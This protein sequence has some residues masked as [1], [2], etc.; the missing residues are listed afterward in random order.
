MIFPG[1]AQVVVGPSE[2]VVGPSENHL[3]NV[4]GQGYL[5]EAGPNPTSSSSNA[6]QSISKGSV[7]YSLPL[8]QQ[9]TQ[10]QKPWRIQSAADVVLMQSNSTQS[11]TQKTLQQ[12]S[13]LNFKK[14]IPVLMML[15]EDDEINIA[16][17]ADAG[18]DQSV[19]NGAVVTLNGAASTDANG[20]SLTYSWS[21][22]VRPFGSTAMLTNVSSASPSFTADVVGS[23]VIGLIVNDGTISSLQSS[24]KETL[25]NYPFCVIGVRPT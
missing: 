1:Y 5:K 24:V 8:I 20:D 4:R 22:L 10:I 17:V 21:F 6:R 3:N 25:H 11:T 2:F 16:P 13:A 23:Y 19:T 15:L 9:S 12:A 14:I 18:T 7:N